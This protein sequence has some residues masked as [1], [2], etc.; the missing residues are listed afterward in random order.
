LIRGG[1]PW[2]FRWSVRIAVAASIVV[3][4]FLPYHYEIGGDFRVAPK[5]ERGLRSLLADEL[6]EVRIQ[7]GQDVPADY[8]VAVLSAR[9][10]ESAVELAKAELKQAQANL[11]L[12]RAGSR[13]EDIQ[14]AELQL[15]LYQ[16]Q[17]AFRENE[18]TRVKK[19]RESNSATPQ[20]LE[21]A[22]RASDVATS[23]VEIA[24]ERLGK[25]KNGPRAEEVQEA[26]AAVEAA[27]VKLDL[28]QRKLALREIKTPIAGRIA[29]PGL[30]AKQGQFLQEGELLAVVQDISQ[31]HAEMAADEAA[32]ANI[33]VGM[34]VKLR[35]NGTYGEL[36]MGKVS[37]IHAHAQPYPHFANASVRSDREQSL[38]GAKLDGDEDRFVAVVID[39]DDREYQ[40]VP[41]MTGY[42]RV[43]VANDYFWS[44]LGRSLA[45]FFRVD[46]W[47]WLP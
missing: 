33:K 16:T 12:L 20:E 15:E 22:Q 1:G 2:W 11:D 31:V 4:G 37:A 9:E 44:V 39:L 18:L 26:E 42:A 29:S 19:L 32:A 25:V 36:L 21:R 30:A 35:L 13:P 41:G 47:S 27:K 28:N 40:V 3:L 17:T 7:D 10:E 45:R 24:K 23:M 6:A 46:V 43:V 14:L 34:P 5:Q 8:V 38:Q